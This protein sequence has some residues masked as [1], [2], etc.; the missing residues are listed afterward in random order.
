MYGV[1]KA[2]ASNCIQMEENTVDGKVAGPYVS[3]NVQLGTLNKMP[4]RKILLP[5]TVVAIALFGV[6]C[7]GAGFAAVYLVVFDEGK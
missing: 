1:G 2:H 4:R 6:L 5:V 7:F 3:K